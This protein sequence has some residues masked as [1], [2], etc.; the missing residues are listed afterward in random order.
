MKENVNSCNQGVRGHYNFW[1]QLN[2]LLL[3]N[4]Y[5]TGE[6]KFI[7]N[8]WSEIIGAPI[9]ATWEYK[10][11]CEDAKEIIKALKLSYDDGEIYKLFQCLEEL[12]DN[13]KF[14]DQQLN[15][16]LKNNNIPFF[17]NYATREWKKID[18]QEL[19]GVNSMK[20]FLGSSSESKEFMEEIALKLQ[21]LGHDTLMWTDTGKG[22]FAPGTNTIDA[23]IE[24]TKKVDAAVFVFNADDKIWNSNSAL[25]GATTV[26]DNVLFEYGLFTGAL[27]KKKVCFICKNRPSIATDLKGITY[28]D[29]DQKSLIIK[30]KLKD[31]INAM[32]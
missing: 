12:V 31:W 8:R 32:D 27:G 1:N 5:T 24:I 26:R 21:E 30:N 19:L 16:F 6:L 29:G 15:D 11:L 18:S 13:E 28:I 4:G 25:E 3:Q 2:K 22:I 17:Y 23:L 7:L 20:I 9:I 14:T 10:K